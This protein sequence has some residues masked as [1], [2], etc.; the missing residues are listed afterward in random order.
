MRRIAKEQK[1]VEGEE[2]LK[3]LS[4]TQL[5]FLK[6]LSEQA[7]DNFMQIFDMMAI[8]AKESVYVL[9]KPGKSADELIEVNGKQNFHSGRVSMLLLIDYLISHSGKM[10]EK[11]MKGSE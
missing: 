10:L 6:N 8:R 3:L 11:N 2:V 4:N 7:G 5:E 9:S 1:S